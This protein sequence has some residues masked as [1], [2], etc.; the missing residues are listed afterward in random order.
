LVLAFL[1]QLS[2]DAGLTYWAYSPGS[3]ATNGSAGLDEFVDCIVSAQD[4]QRTFVGSLRGV[5]S[6]PL[7]FLH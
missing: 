5:G 6:G 2:L 3:G 4:S 1:G 7:P